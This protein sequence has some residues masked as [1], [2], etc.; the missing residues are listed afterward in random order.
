MVTAATNGW[1]TRIAQRNDHV[2]REFNRYNLPR[3]EIVDP[4]LLDQRIS[5]VFGAN[6][7]QSS[8]G[9]SLEGR[10]HQGEQR[11][12]GF[13]SHRRSDVKASSIG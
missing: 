10:S 12:S 6:D 7:P 9:F 4:R 11:G 3:L 13:H 2:V 5:G 8:A 1:V